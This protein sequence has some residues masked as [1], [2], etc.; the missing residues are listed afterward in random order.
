MRCARAAAGALAGLVVAAA[1]GAGALLGAGVQASAQQAPTLQLSPASG[2]PGSGF[3][4]T[5]GGFIN[6]KCPVVEFRWDNQPIAKAVWAES[7]TV[8]AKV[9]ANA[10]PGPHYVH[11]ATG[12]EGTPRRPFEVFLP[13]PTVTVPPVTTTLRPPTTRPTVPPT[14]TTNSTTSTPTSVTTTSGTSTEPTTTGDPSTTGTG[15]STSA[16]PGGLTFDKPVVQAG[17]PLSASGSGC[18]PGARVSL[19]SAGGPVGST[20]ADSGGHFTTPVEF[21]D[22]QP[23]RHEVTAR[24]GAVLTGSVDVIL[25]SSTQGN[26]STLVVLVFFVLAGV[27]MVARPRG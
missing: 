13:Q 17:D 24:C 20:T 16:G 6:R 15:T 9:P 12:C 4:I 8:G 27:T 23:G 5:F 21:T 25:T 2:A 3:L 19:S 26:T 7:N 14:T 22:I 18:T 1:V 11:G 10:A